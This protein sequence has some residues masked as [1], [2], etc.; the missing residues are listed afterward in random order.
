LS[1]YPE[2]PWTT[3]GQ[4]RFR[5]Y[6]VDADRIQPPNG[7]KLRS[8]VG[9]SLGLLGYIDYRRPSPLPYRELLWMPGR[10]E[11]RDR[12]GRT[13]RGWYVAKMLVDDGASLAA[14]RELW[15]LP[16][17]LASFE[18]SGAEVVMR[19]GDGAV[20][21]WRSRP[22]PGVRGKGAVLT[23]QR[24]Q[25]ELVRFRGVFTGRIAP[26]LCRVD[27]EGLDESWQGLSSAVPFGPLGTELRDFCA[28]MGAPKSSS[29]V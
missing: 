11:V 16:K 20:V 19:A 13:R 21:R 25:N 22:G 14:G 9:R 1:T 24:R 26:A 6:L 5:A 18:S 12:E 8:R 4:A 2:P 23:L 29:L 3:Y 17:E 27:C 10:V 15:A 7:M 28:E